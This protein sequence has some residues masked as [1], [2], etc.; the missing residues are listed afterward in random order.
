M[1]IAS[2]DLL[3]HYGLGGRFFCGRGSDRP[4]DGETVATGWD[5]V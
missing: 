5:S 2:I 3:G 4:G 1:L